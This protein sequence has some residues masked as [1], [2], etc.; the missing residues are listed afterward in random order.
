L[1][2][3]GRFYIYFLLVITAL[4]ALLRL[5]R[6]RQFAELESER[7]QEERA[8][9][10]R[11]WLGM[12]ALC[13]PLILLYK[14]WAPLSAWMWLA[15]VVGTISGVEQVTSAHWHEQRQLL[16][17]T[18]VFGVLSAVTAVCIYAFFVR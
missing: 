15:A 10:R 17:H 9:K 1:D 12:A 3:A 16:L 7:L 2:N 5:A 18:R 4:S 13:S 8:R 6:P 14:F 11:K